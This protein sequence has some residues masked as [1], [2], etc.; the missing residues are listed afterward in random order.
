MNLESILQNISNNWINYR[1]YC[2][3]ESSTG[4]FIHKVKKDHPIHDLVTQSWKQ[5]V[6][7]HVNLK[8]YY[9][10]ILDEKKQLKHVEEEN[11]EIIPCDD[12]TSL[13]S[14]FIDIWL[15][16]D[17]TIISGWNSEFFDIP[18][19]YLKISDRSFYN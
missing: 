17:P 11:K 13:L 8:K 15:V 2:E 19:L 16:C 4:A 10:L 12:E 6:S 18:Y 14:K 7:K 3:A 9:C 5:E 1:K